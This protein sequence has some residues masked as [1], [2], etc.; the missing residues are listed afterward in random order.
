MA[1][2]P[3][4]DPSERE[5][6]LLAYAED[7]LDREQRD[8]FARI[9]RD[10]PQF[11]RIAE[12][13]RSDREQLTSLRS[14]QPPAEIMQNV[15]AAIPQASCF[16]EGTDGAAPV[17]SSPGTGGPY[18]FPTQRWLGWGA[19]AAVLILAVGLGHHL[20][21]PEPHDGTQHGP[22]VLTPP[23]GVG[24]AAPHKRPADDDALAHP[25]LADGEK[26]Q[27]RDL[28]LQAP[29]DAA[30]APMREEAEEAPAPEPEADRDRPARQAV[31]E[32]LGVDRREQPEA[33]PEALERER[34][35]QPLA[36]A[37]R[38]ESQEAVDAA[39]GAP[40][41]GRMLMEGDGVIPPE[42][43]D[44]HEYQAQR[45]TA[46]L[47]MQQYSA[48]EEAAQRLTLVMESRDAD[49]ARERVAR[50]LEAKGDE[51][52]EP[53]QELAEAD[54]EAAIEYRSRAGVP[55]RPWTEDV[56]DMRAFGLEDD[57]AVTLMKVELSPAELRHLLDQIAPEKPMTV[58]MPGPAEGEAA[59]DDEP[60]I[61]DADQHAA[62]AAPGEIPPAQAEAAPAQ[63]DPA[64]RHTRGR[65]EAAAIADVTSDAVEGDGREAFTQ[66]IRLTTDQW[67]QVLDRYIETLKGEQ[68]GP[69]EHAPLRLQL[70]I[71]AEPSPQRDD[72]S[73]PDED[74]ME[75]EQ[76]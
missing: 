74:S 17:A 67:R 69:D 10:D 54:G 3:H 65:D 49:S 28:A 40:R 25:G 62:P 2:N 14:K 7:Q 64:D 5:R 75:A 48:H 68:R 29:E 47:Q 45:A 16:A 55:M 33:A 56:G 76:E 27:R 15:R 52:A 53:Q 30:P 46:L 8:R 37:D 23:E 44:F 18:A 4:I 57:A 20:G 34:A 72:D 35:P 21:H 22:V 60:I 59:D 9:C 38:L 13:L 71:V 19:A 36:E 39:R 66:T 26:P 31:Q 1:E 41:A 63:A 6:L 11:A 61:A 58:A 12:Q 24:D 51:P 73:V 43:A 32:R 50:W 70:L 42:G